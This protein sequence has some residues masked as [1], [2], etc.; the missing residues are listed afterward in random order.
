M[1]SGGSMTNAPKIHITCNVCNGH[2]KDEM[3]VI[4]KRDQG[5]ICDVCVSNLQDILKD[6]NIE[7][8]GIKGSHTLISTNPVKVFNS[9]RGDVPP[10][11]SDGPITA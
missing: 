6:E 10:P 2:Y 7:P 11:A 8:K 4:I 1:V 3:K 9:V 5:H